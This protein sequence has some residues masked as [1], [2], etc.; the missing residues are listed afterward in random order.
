MQRSLFPSQLVT[1]IQP[2][3]ELC[4]QKSGCFV[5]LEHLTKSGNYFPVTVTLTESKP[6]LGK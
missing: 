1:P 3:T 2:A 5:I 4:L 6:L